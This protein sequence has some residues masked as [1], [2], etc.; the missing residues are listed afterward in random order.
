M[1][2]S[3]IEQV[4][5]ANQ[6]QMQQMSNDHRTLREDLD[7]LTNSQKEILSAIKKMIPQGEQGSSSGGQG[8]S[9]SGTAGDPAIYPQLPPSDVTMQTVQSSHVQ[10][11]TRQTFSPKVYHGEKGESFIEWLDILFACARANRWD[12]V[13]THDA[14]QIHSRGSKREKMMEVKIEN[15]SSLT[16]LKEQYKASVMGVLGKIS[17]F[18]SCIG[19]SVYRKQ[20]EN[21][22]QFKTRLSEAWKL[23]SGEHFN[24]VIV[25]KFMVKAFIIGLND[26]NLR[27]KILDQPD[28]DFEATVKFAEMKLME[29]TEQKLENSGQAL[30]PNDEIPGSVDKLQKDDDDQVNKIGNRGKKPVCFECQK[31]GHFAKD[32]YKRRNKEKKQPKKQEK[33]STFKKK[34]SVQE[35]ESDDQDQE[36]QKDF[37]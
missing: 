2:T 5:A 19:I 27:E 33:K 35:L 10:N 4:L 9:S 14:A 15:I 34:K 29:R 24:H 31:P 13:T 8:T 7:R 18:E 3:E 32:C 17:P 22:R 1:E 26:R 23:A 21:I 16:D 6:Q 11:V 30:R 20:G 37:R 28:A 12:I 36:D 25:Q